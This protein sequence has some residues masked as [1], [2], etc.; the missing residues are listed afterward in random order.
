MQIHEL[1]TYKLFSTSFRLCFQTDRF[2]YKINLLPNKSMALSVKTDGNSARTRDS[3]PC[4]TVKL[5]MWNGNAKQVLPK[6][7]PPNMVIFV[8]LSQEVS[9]KSSAKC[10]TASCS[11]KSAECFDKL[12]CYT[13]QLHR[14]ILTHKLPHVNSAFS[15]N[16]DSLSCKDKKVISVFVSVFGIKSCRTRAPV[17]TY[18]FGLQFINFLN[19]ILSRKFRWRFWTKPESLELF[20]C[21]VAQNI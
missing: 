10:G 8:E 13:M 1:I 18:S 16:Y 4:Y 2:D 19:S 5:F 14:E 17:R 9:R 20:A 21:R 12:Q 15:P 6:I 3:T 11:C 7:A